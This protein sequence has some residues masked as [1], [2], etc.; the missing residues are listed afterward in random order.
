MQNL[1]LQFYPIVEE[2]CERW[3]RRSGRYN[4]ISSQDNFEHGSLEFLEDLKRDK[5][6]MNGKL[7][8]LWYRIVT[9]SSF[10]YFPVE[11]L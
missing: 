1:T 8:K 3:R 9:Y 10:F 6:L 5:D 4:S 7:Y 2:N 11:E